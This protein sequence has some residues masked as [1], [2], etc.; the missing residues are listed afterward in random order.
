MSGFEA[1]REDPIVFESQCLNHSAIPGIYEW[2]KC[3]MLYYYLHIQKFIE[4]MMRNSGFQEGFFL[5]FQ[6][7]N[8]LQETS[9]MTPFWSEDSSDMR[10]FLMQSPGYHSFDFIFNFVSNVYALFLWVQMLFK[11]LKQDFLWII[12]NVIN[13]SF[14]YVRSVQNK[15]Q[16]VPIQDI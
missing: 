12:E 2:V 3:F 7:C 4:N 5:V 9:D 11:Y 10:K 15:T 6:G 16:F 14:P 8:L 13:K 1:T